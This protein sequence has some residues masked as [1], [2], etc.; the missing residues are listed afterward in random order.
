[1]DRNLSV[2]QEFYTFEFKPDRDGDPLMNYFQLF[3]NMEFNFIIEL[4]L[5]FFKF[6]GINSVDFVPISQ[7]FMAFRMRFILSVISRFTSKYNTAGYFR[8]D[9]PF[10]RCPESNHLSEDQ[11]GPSLAN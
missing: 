4:F 3:H 7:H 2:L 10:N 9:L 6:F 11:L 8:P 5:Q 1:M